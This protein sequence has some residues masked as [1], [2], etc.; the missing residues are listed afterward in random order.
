MFQFNVWFAVG[1]DWEWNQSWLVDWFATQVKRSNSQSR[2]LADNI[3]GNVESLGGW[4]IYD[5][6]AKEI[7]A[8]TLLLSF[9]IGCSTHDCMLKQRYREGLWLHHACVLIGSDELLWQ[10]VKIKP[11]HPRYSCKLWTRIYWYAGLRL[12]SNVSQHNHEMIVYCWSSSLLR[13]TVCGIR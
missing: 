11:V 12:A 7:Q 8:H 1:W 13:Q 4:W 6:S 9:H 10:F 2:M 5:K 3:Y